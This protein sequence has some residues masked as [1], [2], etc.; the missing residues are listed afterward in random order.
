MI[1]LAVALGVFALLGCIGPSDQRPGMW[2]SGED[3]AFP[4]D[5]SF[6]DAHREIALEVGTPYGLRHSV[7]IWCASMDGTLYIAAR[8]PDE[9]RWPGWVEDRPDVRLRV[10][11]RI[12]EAH[13]VGLD[14]AAAIA[15]LRSRYAAK[16][17]LPDPPPA[18]G[19]PRQYWHVAGS[20]PG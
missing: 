4:E 9:K 15:R 12:Y 1:R 8:D 13:L 20:G 6:T 14:D 10:D 5:W 19:P 16:Y 11:G 18:D 2:L 3:A 7:T 17:D